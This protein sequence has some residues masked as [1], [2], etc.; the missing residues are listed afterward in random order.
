MFVWFPVS[1]RW[2]YGYDSV[3]MHGDIQG[4]IVYIC[5]KFGVHG[6]LYIEVEV[7]VDT[8]LVSSAHRI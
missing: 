6:K 1:S 4:E 5:D 8:L 3:S 2:R 7:V